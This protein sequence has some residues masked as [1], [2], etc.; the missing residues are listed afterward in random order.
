MRSVRDLMTADVVWVSPT[1]S[2]KTAIILMRGH[3]IGA[4]P[5]VRDGAG[6]VGLVTLLNLL[7]EPQD[8][9]VEEIMDKDYAS[10]DPDTS[11]H[12]AAE[13]M[14][15]V[16]ASHLL[17]IESDRLVGIIS[18]GD[19][20]PELGRTFDPLTELPW[21][22][23][24]R[25]WAINA[26]KRGDEI[27]IILFDLDQFGIFNKKHGHVVGDTVLKQVA[28]VLKT[29]T[30]SSLELVCRYGGDEFAIVS[31]RL[32]DEAA[33]L[34][35]LLQERI[36]RLSIEGVP[37]R[38][39]TTFGISGGR[40]TREREDMHYAATL[41]DLIT[42]A[43]KECMAKKPAQPEAIEAP[44]AAPTKG[45]PGFVPTHTLAP[46]PGRAPRLKIASI[47]FA[48][49]GAQAKAGVTLIREGREFQ[50]EVSG[51]TVGGNSILRLFAEATAA[52]ACKS[53]AP[54][55]GIVVEDASL[56]ESGKEDRIVSVVAMFISPRQSTRVTGSALIRR[57]DQYRAAAAAL[58]NAVNRQLE[59]A[60]QAAEEEGNV[61]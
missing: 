38:I 21:S 24:F 48:S 42:R 34:A 16:G 52:A 29:G 18:R 30:D 33:S 47:S 58:L 23:T 60:P 15:Q 14:H 54:D 28:D 35:N 20:L 7:G 36:G 59:L 3:N 12:D 53:L 22:D 2:V 61:E 27:A 43:S 11:A 17:V 8:A 31:I 1:A 45:E 50:R 40:R 4:L 13:L 32:H 5:V 26:L 25:E 51:Y 57:G 37:E 10:V 9:V 46:P 49:T 41:D 19:L 56:Q 55:H 44:A 6:V 39:S